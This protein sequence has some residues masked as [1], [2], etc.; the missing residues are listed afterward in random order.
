MSRQCLA[1]YDNE[2]LRTCTKH[3]VIN[4]RHDFPGRWP[5]VVDSINVYLSSGLQSP[6]TDGWCWPGAL[7]ATY[8]LVKNSEYKKK[9]ERGPIYDAFNLLLPQIYQ[10]RGEITVG[11]EKWI[12]LWVKKE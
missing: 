9:E 2:L 7:L 4:S 12:S 3:L 11:S 1:S 8:Q 5:T 10:V 6:E